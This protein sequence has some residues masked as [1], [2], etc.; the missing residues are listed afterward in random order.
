MTRWLRAGWG[1][2]LLALAGCRHVP[3]AERGEQCALA[4]EHH[5][6]TADGAAI[7]LHRHPTA[8]PPVLVLH[9]I[10]SNHRCWDLD[11]SRSLA[12]ALNAAGLDAWLLDLRGHGE[13][14]VDLAG[15]EQRSGWRIDDYGR[16]DIPAAIDRIREVTGQAQVG[17]VGHSLGGMSAAIYTAIHGDDALSAMVIVASP[18][19]FGDPDPLLTMAGRALSMSRLLRVVPAPMAGRLA[20]DW[21]HLPLHA[22]A[23]LWSDDNLSD[24]ARAAMMR[25][26]VSPMSRHE[27]AELRQILRSG[28][29][30]AADA[31]P[32]LQTPLRVIAGRGDRVAPPDRVLPYYEAAGSAEKS[33]IL[34]GRAGGFRHDYGHLDLVVG[35]DAAAE[36]YPLITEWLVGRE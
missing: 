25:S 21:R 3:L 15:D 20:A 28:R 1:V 26:V 33:Y 10:S 9:G 22:D 31:L 19:D 5:V 11:A 6:A 17:F 13:A 36:I 12:V 29:L 8:G 7:H 34:A 14:H 24:D 32:R 27:L 4:E 23:L 16:Y 2:L 18:V 35:D 30:P